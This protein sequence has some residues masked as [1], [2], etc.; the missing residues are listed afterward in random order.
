M[1][2][3]RKKQ[4]ATEPFKIEYVVPSRTF[5]LP[6]NKFQYIRDCK[7]LGMLI[8]VMENCTTEYNKDKDCY[9]VTGTV[10]GGIDK[11]KPLT[12]GEK[13]TFYYITHQNIQDGQRLFSNNESR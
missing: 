9:T 4:T 10:V 11:D 3:V 6:D 2:K 12:V 1:R 8:V 7:K 13:R 5:N